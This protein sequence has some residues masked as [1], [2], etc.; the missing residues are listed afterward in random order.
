MTFNKTRNGYNILKKPNHETTGKCSFSLNKNHNKN[1]R[2]NFFWSKDNTFIPPGGPL[3]GK[4]LSSYIVKRVNANQTT[5][6]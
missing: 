2:R 5:F 1:F 3:L 6:A 4:C